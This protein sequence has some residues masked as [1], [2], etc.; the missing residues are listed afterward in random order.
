MSTIR[1]IA[2]KLLLNK[3]AYP[4]VEASSLEKSIEGIPAYILKSFGTKNPDKIFYVIRRSPGSGFFSNIAYVLNHLKICDDLGFTPMVDFENFPTL[5]NEAS[6]I[7]GTKNAWEYYFEPISRYSLDE[8]YQSTSVVITDGKWYPSMPMS[9]TQDINLLAIFTKYIKP[10]QDILSESKLFFD[11]HFKNEKVLAIHFRGQELRTAR[12]HPFPPTKQQI[13]SRTRSL[14]A[15]HGFTRIFVSTES[16]DYFN[17]LQNAFGSMA[18]SFPSYRSNRNSYLEHPRDQHRYL[19]GRDI[20]I[21]MLLMSR[22]DALLCGGSNVSETAAFLAQ[23]KPNYY[24]RI[25]NGTNSHNPVVAKYLWY[26]K[27]LLPH[28]LGGFH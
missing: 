3:V 26:L 20:L 13:V 7:A 14:L 6:P 1:H 4:L 10:K 21:E 19:L 18:C 27:A 23:H 17:Y 9:I 8:I 24:Q 15:E 25:W 28:S 5:Y 11:Q 22:A 16:R 2:R 12:G